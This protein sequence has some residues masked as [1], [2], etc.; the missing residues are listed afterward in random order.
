[1][2]TPER[3]VELPSQL[4]LTAVQVM[5]SVQMHHALAQTARGD[6]SAI[7]RQ[8]RAQAVDL[9]RVLD[10]IVA[11]EVTHLARITVRGSWVPTETS[12]TDTTSS[13]DHV[14]GDC[15]G[16]Y[17]GRCYQTCRGKSDFA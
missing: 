2:R 1:M 10:V 6:A 16:P 15:A 7:S 17:S 3:L 9:M 8:M 12:P 5:W 4:A 14:V 11:G 13:T